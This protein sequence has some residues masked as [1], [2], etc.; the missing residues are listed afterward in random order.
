MPGM[1]YEER[2]AV[3]RGRRERAALQRRP[4]GGPR[5]RPRDVRQRPRD[6]AAWRPGPSAQE[7][8]DDLVT[9]LDRFTGDEHEQE[10]DITLVALGRS[11]DAGRSWCSAEF[12]VQSAPGNERAAIDQVVAAVEGLPISPARLERLKT[13]TAE[14]TMNAMEHGNRYD[15]GCPVDDRRLGLRGSALRADHRPG[16]RPRQFRRPRRARPR[17]QARRPPVA[18]RLGPVPDPEHGGR[19][20]RLA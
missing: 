2:E 1:D 16:R 12:S 5:A 8:I 13:A 14:A 9:Q 15:P 20:R 17:G 18:A 7:L 6:R 4:G 3:A 19:G 10:D 11:P